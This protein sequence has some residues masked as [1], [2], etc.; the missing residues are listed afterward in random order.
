MRNIDLAIHIMRATEARNG[1]ICVAFGEH[2]VITSVMPITGGDISNPKRVDG[3][4]QFWQSQSPCP[5]AHSQMQ[6]L[7]TLFDAH[8][9]WLDRQIRSDRNGLNCPFNAG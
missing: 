3:D 1:L 9:Y 8:P 7:I 5:M 2:P 6:N 4:H